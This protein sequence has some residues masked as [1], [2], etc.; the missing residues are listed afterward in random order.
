MNRVDAVEQILDII[1]S[2]YAIR[3]RE[4]NLITWS[5]EVQ[6]PRDVLE[7]LGTV[8]D[9]ARP[10]RL[11]RRRTTTKQRPTLGGKQSADN[12]S[13]TPLV[14]LAVVLEIASLPQLFMNYRN[15]NVPHTMLPPALEEISNH[16]AHYYNNLSV[17][18]TQ[19]QGDEELIHVGK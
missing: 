14:L 3:M 15:L 4:L 10:S 18:I 7:V 16:R 8:K 9:C 6:L 13:G 5:Q 2:D 1:F 17:T 19:F 12:S 11:A